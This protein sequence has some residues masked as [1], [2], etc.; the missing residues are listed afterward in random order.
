[1]IRE[2]LESKRSV[3]DKVRMLIDKAL[4][5]GG[6]DN[7]SVIIVEQAGDLHE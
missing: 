1:M 6:Y 5:A 2:S 7:V 4:L 3:E